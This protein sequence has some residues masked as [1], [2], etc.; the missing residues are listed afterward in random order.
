MG[1]L[2]DVAGERP[3]EGVRG[4][5]LATARYHAPAGSD[6]T[7]LGPDLSAVLETCGLVSFTPG[8]PGPTLTAERP[9]TSAS[10]GQ[11][12]LRLHGVS[13]RERTGQWAHHDD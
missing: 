4:R 3:C 11:G 1:D 9:V 6:P 5:R 8:Q 7:W 13:Q 2:S 12:K 10:L